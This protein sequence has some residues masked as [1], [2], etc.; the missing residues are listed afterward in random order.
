M[1]SHGAINTQFTEYRVLRFG[2]YT[3]GE[4]LDAPTPG[5]TYD[6]FQPEPVLAVA[7]QVV[8]KAVV[9]T[10][11]PERQISQIAERHPA[12]AETIHHHRNANF[13]QRP[14][15]PA[16]LFAMMVQ[17]QF[18]NAYP[19]PGHPVPGPGQRFQQVFTEAVITNGG[20]PQ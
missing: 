10:N 15:Q 18:G 4:H 3:G 8:D 20:D 17:S 12:N 1:V 14:D 13:R 6:R 11:A 19:Q 16:S 9:D 2:F 7:V 5:N